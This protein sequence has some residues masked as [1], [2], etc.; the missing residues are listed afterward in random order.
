MRL[1]TV[2]RQSLRQLMPD[3]GAVLRSM[4][5]TLHIQEP[6]FKN[7]VVLYR[8]KV[9]ATPQRK[10]EYEPIRSHNLVRPFNLLFFEFEG[11]HHLVRLAS[12][13]NASTY[14]CPACHAI[15]TTVELLLYHMISISP[16]AC[17]MEA[18]LKTSRQGC[19]IAFS[20]RGVYSA[21][22]H[23]LLYYQALERRNINIKRFAEIPM[24]DA[25]MVFPDKKIY[26]KP[27]LLIQL[28]IAI[29]GGLIAAFTA[30]LSVRAPPLTCRKTVSAMSGLRFTT[31]QGTDI[32]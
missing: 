1:Q 10:S 21:S 9:A 28:A 32:A 26:L 29:I 11:L 8:R 5:A 23:L 20:H 19:N 15:S 3:A 7:V 2:Q 4:F 6:A 17:G 13:S 16:A 31:L 18:P 30:L 22:S 27:L 12:Q 25:E 14:I 24:A